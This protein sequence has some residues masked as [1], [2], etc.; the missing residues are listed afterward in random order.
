MIVWDERKRQ[1]N[2]AKHGL[3]FADAYLVYE[4]PRKVTLRSPRGMENRA[5]DLAVVE[6]AGTVLVLVYVERGPDVRVISFR[7]ASRRERK[8]YAR[9]IDEKSD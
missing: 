8:L 9:I 6:I 4:N 3:D 7:R 1:T 2:L 5:M